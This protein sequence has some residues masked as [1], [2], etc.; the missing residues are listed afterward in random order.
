MSDVQKIDYADRTVD[1]LMLKTVLNVPAVR[2]RVNI[3]ISDVSG[4]PMIVSGVEKMVQRF[5]L[6]FINAMGSTRFRPNHGT[7]LVPEVSRGAVYDMATLEAVAAE[8]NLIAGREIMLADSAEDTPDDELL[9]GSSILDLEFSREKSMAMI[10]I[11]LT[12]AAGR[13]YT[14]IIPVDVGVH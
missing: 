1:L 9:V 3:D 2:E 6:S 4:V 14:Y 11:M 10:S 8:A 12:T 5:A 13:S 7:S